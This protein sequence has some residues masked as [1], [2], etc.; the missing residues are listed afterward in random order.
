MRRSY[1]FIGSRWKGGAGLADVIRDLPGSLDEA[2]LTVFAVVLDVDL[3][4]GGFGVFRLEDAIEEKLDILEDFAVAPDEA[5]LL[6]GVDLE[7]DKALALLLV[8]FADK[9]EVSKHGVEDILGGRAHRD[10]RLLV[11]VFSGAG[12]VLF[13]VTYNWVIE[14]TFCTVKYSASADA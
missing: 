1:E 11:R 13:L 6:R 9:A 7:E 8:D 10:R 5:I 14:K 2:I 3:N 4:A 12:A